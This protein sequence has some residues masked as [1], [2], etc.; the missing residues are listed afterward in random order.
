MDINRIKAQI[1][2]AIPSLQE[3]DFNAVIDMFILEHKMLGR[4]TEYRL[5]TL[6]YNSTDNTLQLPVDV[7][8]VS[9]VYYNDAKL[10]RYSRDDLYTS[11]EL[12]YWLGED[13]VLYLNF[14]ITP[15]VMS[16]TP[17]TL[18]LSD[19]VLKVYAKMTVDSISDYE[20]KWLIVCVK[21]CLKELYKSKTYRDSELYAIANN[22]Y[23]TLKAM[24]G[25]LNR[26][27]LRM[28]FMGDY[29]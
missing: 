14:A 7:L 3:Y 24:V 6:S 18:H 5:S 16:G 21:Y 25:S 20:D 17:S 12:G 1:F 22:D 13:G 15:D 9:E 10:K 8:T 28:E 23:R 4:M 11:F 29:L 19:D 2:L 26:Q 27:K